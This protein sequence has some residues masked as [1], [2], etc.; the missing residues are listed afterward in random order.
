MLFL[1]P[2]LSRV[3]V[4]LSFALWPSKQ[5]GHQLR[6][7]LVTPPSTAALCTDCDAD[8]FI[9]Q[10][11]ISSAMKH[12][13]ILVSDDTDLLILLLHLANAATF[14]IYMVSETKKGKKGKTWDILK[15]SEMSGSNISQL[16]LFAHAIVGYDTTSKPYGLGKSSALKLF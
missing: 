6:S 11:A 1:S 13:T 12:S 15:I 10:Q 16:L 14:P 9:V 2:F 7:F 3:H 4:F 8:V 5:L